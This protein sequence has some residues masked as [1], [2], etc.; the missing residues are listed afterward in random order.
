MIAV[1]LYAVLYDAEG[2]IR[3]RMSGGLVNIAATAATLGMAAL[4]VPDDRQYERTHR[5]AD[6]ALVPIGAGA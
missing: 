5:V 4:M 3:Q 6:G 2:T 1:A